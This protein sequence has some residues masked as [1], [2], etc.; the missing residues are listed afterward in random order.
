MFKTHTSVCWSG[1][2]SCMFI[3]LY[4]ERR[5][6]S[7]FAK[8]TTQKETASIYCMQYDPPRLLCLWGRINKGTF[9]DAWCKTKFKW[10]WVNGRANH[11]VRVSVL[12]QNITAAEI[13][14]GNEVERKASRQERRE[15][16]EV[17]TQKRRTWCGEDPYAHKVYQ[18]TPLNY[19]L[20]WHVNYMRGC[21]LARSALCPHWAQPSL[22]LSLTVTQSNIFF[23]WSHYAV[24]LFFL[25]SSF[26]PFVTVP[27]LAPPSFFLPS[28]KSTKSF[29]SLL[30]SVLNPAYAPAS[31]WQ[32]ACVCLGDV[33]R[34]ISLWTLMFPNGWSVHYTILPLGLGS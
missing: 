13:V 25:Q 17:R 26:H 12:G 1:V 27:E 2:H 33:S 6:A 20:Y 24:W 18:P 22:H 30:F 10:V 29:L 5:H 8:Q 32:P 16:V 28:S 23:I 9:E 14:V 15:S 19:H 21:C 31:H 11:K 34:I 7:T 3:W 4:R